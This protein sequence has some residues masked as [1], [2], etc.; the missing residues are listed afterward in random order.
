[1]FELTE[2]CV[3]LLA[4]K[5]VSISREKNAIS[6]NKLQSRATRVWNY[7]EI[8]QLQACKMLQGWTNNGLAK[9]RTCRQK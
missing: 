3:M 7:N 1:M 2:S 4:T 6:K 8:C 5:E 9:R